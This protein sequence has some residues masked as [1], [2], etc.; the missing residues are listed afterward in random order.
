MPG[1]GPVLAARIITYQEEF[2]FDSVEDLIN[3]T[4]IGAKTLEQIRD[5]FTCIRGLL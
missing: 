5:Y 2:G 1:I 3:I 4:G